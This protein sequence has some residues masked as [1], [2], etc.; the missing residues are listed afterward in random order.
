MSLDK[1][2]NFRYLLYPGFKSFYLSNST[3]K[4]SW[5][6]LEFNLTLESIEE[7]VLKLRFPKDC[8]K[9]PKEDLKTN[10]EEI[11][12]SLT[13]PPSY[14][15]LFELFCSHGIS[16]FG[17]DFLLCFGDSMKNLKLSSERS[18][19]YIIDNEIAYLSLRLW[20][21]CYGGKL[22]PDLFALLSQIYSETLIPKL[23]LL[24]DYPWDW[25]IGVV[26]NCGKSFIKRFVLYPPQTSSGFLFLENSPILQFFDSEISFEKEVSKVESEEILY[27]IVY[28]EM[29]K[30]KSLS[31]N[32]FG[33]N[34]GGFS[35]V[36]EALYIKREIID[37]ALDI[38]KESKEREEKNM[39]FI[40]GRIVDLLCQFPN[41]CHRL[42][43]VE[44]LLIEK[45]FKVPED[46]PQSREI[47]GSTTELG[48]LRELAIN[49]YNFSNSWKLLKIVIPFI[50]EMRLD[51]HYAIL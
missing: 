24:N 27:D 19:R 48:L 22:D 6:T 40:K 30:I 1:I 25:G 34:N 3:V 21:I 41:I 42:R 35:F 2:C 45:L 15:E 51:K 28:S 5:K 7:R 49:T 32:I 23:I 10:N 46:I 17:G 43:E 14:L 39:E 18:N 36:P 13:F 37:L 50:N 4:Y 8:Y 47:L 38:S 44:P 29:S 12:I 11:G 20:A 31:K 26:I 16:E 33:D 9:V